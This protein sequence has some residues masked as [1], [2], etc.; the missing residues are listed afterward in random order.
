MESGSAEQASAPS[1]AASAVQG[2]HGQRCQR[3]G[4]RYSARATIHEVPHGRPP[5]RRARHRQRHRRRDRP[6]RGRFPGGAGH[7]QRRHGADRRE[8]APR[9]SIRPWGR[10]WK[11]RA[12]RP[13]TP[14]S[15]WRASAAAPPS[16]ARSRT[17]SSAAPSRTTSAP[18]A[19]PSTPSRRAT[20]PS[21]ARC[22]IMVTPDG[23]RTMNT[24]LGAAQDLKP[25]DIDEAKIASAARHLSRRLSVGSAAGQGS[26][27]QGGGDRAQGTGGASRSR[28]RMP[29]A[30]TAIAPNSST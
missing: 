3:V 13:P 30:S 2:L 26:L 4:R 8:R 9:R 27:R 29:S 5:L 25:A 11:A 22:Y 1:L 21:T 12:A 19:S 18:P 16:S 17:T 14:S 15:A 28:C 23:E 6:R 24:F 10:R 7:A 20:G